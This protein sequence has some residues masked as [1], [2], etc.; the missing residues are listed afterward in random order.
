MSA[1]NY[2]S[3]QIIDYHYTNKKLEKLADLIIMKVLLYFSN[4]FPFT[5]FQFS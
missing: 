2:N 1:E 3:T 5:E 4:K